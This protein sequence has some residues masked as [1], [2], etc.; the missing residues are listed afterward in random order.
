M[1][2]GRKGLGSSHRRRELYRYPATLCDYERLQL[3]IRYCHSRTAADKRLAPPNE[4]EKKSTAF[5][6][7]PA[8]VVVSMPVSQDQSFESI[9]IQGQRL[10]FS[11]CTVSLRRQALEFGRSC[12][13]HLARCY[14]GVTR[15][16]LRD[17]C[18]MLA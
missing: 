17:C 4:A 9:L 6:C 10:C 1:Q 3:C 7:F 11:Y 12:V 14:M 13:L 5:H 8:W 18:R 16:F 2:A 15:N